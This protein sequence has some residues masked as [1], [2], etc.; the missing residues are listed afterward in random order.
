[1]EP[2]VTASPQG[3]QGPPHAGSLV[4]IDQH[5]SDRELADRTV[6]AITVISEIFGAQDVLDI[7]T[8]V[9]RFGPAQV[10]TWVENWCEIKL[11]ADL[12]ERQRRAAESDC[13]R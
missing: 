2:T 8:S 7:V 12:A 10:R 9:E 11:D 3:S 1:M 6:A 4:A 5:D 13:R